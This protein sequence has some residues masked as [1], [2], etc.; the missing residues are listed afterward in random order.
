LPSV[1]LPQTQPSCLTDSTTFLYDCG[2][3]A[4]SASWTVPTTATSGIYFAKLTRGDTLGSSDVVF[5]VRNDASTSDVIFQTSD[6]TWQAYDQS[7]GNS[8]YNGTN[9]KKADKVSYNRPTG[10]SQLTSPNWVFGN[11]YP[12]VRWL[13]L[14][15]YNVSYSSGV[16]TDRRGSL[17]R[18]H[19]VFLSVGHDEYW[20]A[21]QR[22][23]VLA[24]RDAGVNLAFF[25]GNTS[26]WKTRWETSIDGSGTSYRTLVTYKETDSG[27]IDP[28]DP[29]IWTGTWRDATY[30]PPDD[31]GRPENAMS[32]QLP[33]VGS[34]ANFDMIVPQ[35]LGV[36]RY[37]R[38]TAAAT[39]ANGQSL[40]ISAGCDCL[41]GYEFDED[42]DNGFRPA[43]IVHLSSTTDQVLHMIIN[44]TGSEIGPG[45]AT[46][47][48]TLYRAP[49]GALVFGAGTIN[50][51]HGLDGNGVPPSI[52]DLNI[53]QATVNLLADMGVQPATLQAGLVLAT[54]STDRTPPVSQITSPSVGASIAANAPTTVSGTAIDV[55]GNVGGVDVSTDGGQT[56]HPATGLETWTYAWTPTKG[57]STTIL[58]RAVDDSGNLESPGPG[59]SVDVLVSGPTVTPTPTV[60]P[61]GTPHPPPTATAS[62]TKTPIPTV[63]L[64]PSRTATPQPIGTGN[65]LTP[66]LTATATRTATATP[67]P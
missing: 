52:P 40:T 21:A 22:A 41:L 44:A 59:V 20:S 25:S 2:N 57:G 10:H 64:G 29:P 56:W 12:M 62:H 18:Q 42:V 46:H 60:T 45:T 4:V 19:R 23:N 36:M 67:A 7:G 34:G 50:W 37:W 47:T 61:P 53:Q 49:S 9:N 28:L 15:G 31:G 27:R 16:D 55:G 66:T 24:A 54:A 14:N 13:E 17:I 6:T 11:E 33:M 58:S 1:S 51:A 30:S 39:L 43:G 26:L 48:L 63:T 35:A 32:G 65:P 38:N 8:L 5:V 3:W